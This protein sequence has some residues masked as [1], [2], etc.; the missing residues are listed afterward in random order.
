M[1]VV[2]GIVE[3]IEGKREGKGFA[4]RW[5]LFGTSSIFFWTTLNVASS[6]YT[7]WYKGICTFF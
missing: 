1:V 4:I 6:D 2:R 5:L 3:R 7:R